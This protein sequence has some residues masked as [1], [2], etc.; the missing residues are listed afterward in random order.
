MISEESR[1]TRM[2]R[3]IP[4]TAFVNIKEV[5]T[6]RLRSS[7]EICSLVADRFRF[8]LFRKLLPKFKKI[9]NSVL[10]KTIKS[11]T[12]KNSTR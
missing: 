3:K 11:R 7:S 6:E 2:T 10:K 9:K 4:F 8:M 12:V 5:I 1:E